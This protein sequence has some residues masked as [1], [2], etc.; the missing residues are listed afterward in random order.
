M[1]CEIARIL[2]QKK[3]KKLEI[4]CVALLSNF[5]FPLTFTSRIIYRNEPRVTFSRVEKC[6]STFVNCLVQQAE[7]SNKR[8]GTLR[9][10]FPWG[11][12]WASLAGWNCAGVIL[13]HENPVNRRL[14]RINYVVSTSQAPWVSDSLPLNAKTLRPFGATKWADLEVEGRNRVK[15][16]RNLETS[17]VSISVTLGNSPRDRY[18][19]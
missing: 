9:E 3:N 6:P 19:T 5:R 14:W 2:V 1:S 17:F 13:L 4:N 18:W 11:W 7:G 15:D 10:Y 8:D 12:L 16:C